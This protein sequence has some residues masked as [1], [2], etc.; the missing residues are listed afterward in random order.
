MCSIV[1]FIEKRNK[2][3]PDII[4][5]MNQI[6]KHRGPDDS[7]TKILKMFGAASDNVAVAHNRLSIRDLTFAGHQPMCN[8]DESV[9]LLFNGEIYNADDFRE[10]ISST[11]Y[12]FRGNSDTE[13]LLWLYIKYGLKEM[14]ARIDGMYAICII[15]VS[16]DCIYLVRDKIGEKPL[17][18]Y[19]NDEVFLWGSEYKAFYEHPS[20]IPVLEEK[21]LTEYLMFRYIVGGETLLKGVKN[22]TPGS[23]LMI[24]D[25]SITECRYWDFPPE[26]DICPLHED[27][28]RNEFI[29]MLQRA[30]Q[31]RLVSD[32]EIGIQ[33]SGG[34]DSSCLTEYVSRVFKSRIKT[35]GIVFEGKEYSEKQYMDRVLS[36]CSADFNMYN[37]TNELFLDSWI[38]TTY[39]FEAPM[40]HEGTVGLFHL[41]KLASEKIRVMLCGEGADETMG[42]YHR[43]Y[44]IL[45]CRASLKYRIRRIAGDLLKRK[46]LNK[47]IIKKD[48]D[49]AFIRASQF[50]RDE[51]VKKIYDKNEIRKVIDH[52]RV[53]L[54]NTAGTGM[55]KLMNYETSTYCQDLLMRA[56][57]ISMAHSIEQRV[58]Y[59]KPQ[60]V[61]FLCSVPSS[62]FVSGDSVGGGV[63]HNTKKLLKEY[64][65]DIFD[66]EFAYR[67]KMGFGISLSDYFCDGDVKKY[68]EDVLLPGIRDRR[69]FNYNEIEQM[70]TDICH[71]SSRSSFRKDESKINALW[72][73]FSFEIWAKMYLDCNPNTF[74]HKT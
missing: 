28:I 53:V 54:N 1:G 31:S 10:E 61:E 50:V 23:Y 68:I 7:G 34:V 33:L 40:N 49:A 71:K 14:L 46:Q 52:R 56:D 5:R 13:V 63:T 60:L 41:N 24:R 27:A 36:Q 37:F 67:S 26:R 17:Y 21:N 39:Y 29:Q 43:F 2:A 51:K 65:A 47:E 59:L 62:F 48:W 35:F 25:S 70:Y 38:K 73:A 8:D 11:G 32:V 6:L 20:F 66:G 12:I 45:M 64:C 22:L 57:K 42:G 9:I 69:I 58:P 15:D 74:L 4:Y 44:D 3:T 19:D 18:Y 16:K 30:Y 72:T 55:R